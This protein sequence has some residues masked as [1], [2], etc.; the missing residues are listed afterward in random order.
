MEN[1][2]AYC[3]DVQRFEPTRSTLVLTPNESSRLLAGSYARGLGPTHLRINGAVF[4][5]ASAT[6]DTITYKVGPEFVPACTLGRGDA[7][8][9]LPTSTPFVAIALGYGVR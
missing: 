1:V 5:V 3:L 8:T 2:R 7:A 6:P 4:A 9:S